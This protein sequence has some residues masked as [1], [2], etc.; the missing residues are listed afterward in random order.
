MAVPVRADAEEIM[1]AAARVKIMMRWRAMFLDLGFFVASSRRRFTFRWECV[2]LF[3]KDL[4][5]LCLQSTHVKCLIL[6]I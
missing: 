1:I 6:G 4:L 5:G 2:S 3:I